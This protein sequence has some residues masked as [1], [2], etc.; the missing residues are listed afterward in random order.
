MSE[1][2][3]SEPRSS[4]QP[5]MSGTASWAH[6]VGALLVD[7]L[8]CYGFA[9]FVLQDIQH[10][11]FGAV[12]IVAFLVESALGVALS[13]GSFGQLV[14]R[15]RVYRIDG[16]PLPLLPAFARQLLVCLLIPPLVFRSDGRGL[17]DLLTTSAAFPLRRNA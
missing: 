14:T 6:R 9:A 1:N 7:W 15:I 10:P 4:G 17:H 11:A 2:P 5:I 12:V 13:G 8:A 3:R 16:T